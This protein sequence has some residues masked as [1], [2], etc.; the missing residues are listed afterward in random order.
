[1]VGDVL[2]ACE[3][4]TRRGAGAGSP[5]EAVTSAKVERLVRLAEAWQVAHGVRAEEVRIDLMAIV[6]PARG[7]AVVE[8][9]RGLV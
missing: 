1:M 3:V 9:V 2:V 8:H 7:S 5:H 4:K 6:Q